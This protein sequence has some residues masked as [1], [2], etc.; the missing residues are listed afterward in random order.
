MI[1][2]SAVTSAAV[3]LHLR[4]PGWATAGAVLVVNGRVVGTLAANSI[5]T[6][7]IAG[8]TRATVQLQFS[9]A[10]TV[11]P[12]YLGAATVYRGPLHFVHHIDSK[13][14]QLA[15]Y[16]Y[17]S[18]DY[19]INATAPWNVGIDLS[20][21]LTLSHRTPVGNP[22]F[23]PWTC[24]L[25]ISGAGRV[26]PGWV[27]VDSAA[28]PPPQSPINSTQPLQVMQLLPM[29]CTSLRIAQMPILKT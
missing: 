18:S 27:E 20:T 2:A 24:A 11:V 13:W 1:Q 5:R 8:N 21:N 25:A 7:T 17:N 6:V 12:R 29:G 19:A 15:Q 10:I 16:A 22:P 23:S 9:P 26:I 28:S 3:P 14:I 4:V